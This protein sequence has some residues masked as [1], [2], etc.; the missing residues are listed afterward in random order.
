MPFDQDTRNRLNRFVSDARSLL[1]DEFTNLLQQRYGMDP[2]SGSVSPMDVL[3][4]LD[5]S[6]R[7]TARILRETL[8]YYHSENPDKKQTKKQ[9]LNRILREQAF[10]VLNRLCALRLA[11][12]R[13]LI[14]ETIAKGY[15][16]EGFLL[17]STLAGPALGETMDAYRTYLFSLFDELAVE[18]PPLFD[19]FSPEGRLFPRQTSLQDLLALIN[20]QDLIGLWSEDE[21]IGWIYQYFNSQEERRAMRAASSAPRNSRELAVRNQFFTPRYVVEFLTDNTLGRIWF[22]MTKGQTGL[23]D[24][25]NY[26]VRR[27]HTFFLDEGEEAPEPFDPLSTPNGDTD[28][29]GDMW[30]P[31]N[32]DLEE[33][34]HIFQYAVT[35]DGYHYAKE[36]L[37]IECGDLVNAKLKDY[38]ENGE[39]EGTFEELRCCLFFEQRRYHHFGRFPEGEEIETIQ[40]LYRAICERWDYEVEFVPFRQLKDPRE[41]KMLDPAC[42]SMHFGLYAFDLF[43][44]IYAEA[45]EVEE[46]N[47]ENALWRLADLDSLHNTYPNKES[48]ILDVPRLIIERNIHGIDIDQRAVQIAGL[49]LWLRAQ[50]TWSTL[51]M[52]KEVRPQIRK[53]NIVCAEPMP[54]NRNIL[55]EFLKTLNQ[56]HLKRMIAEMLPSYIVSS[57]RVTEKMV[58]ALR[59]LVREIWVAM[60]LAG[61]AGSLLKIEE[62]LENAVIEAREK[63][64]NNLP[65]LQA[66]DFEL[67]DPSLSNDMDFWNYSE[68]LVMLALKY[69]SIRSYNSNG[70]QR[71]VFTNDAL[72]GFGFLS[73]NRKSFDVV[74][75][76]PPFGLPSKASEKYLSQN[77]PKSKKDIYAIFVD[78]WGKK[79]DKGKLGVISNRT[80]MFL[81]TMQKW[82]EDSLLGITKISILADLGD[83]VLDNALVEA[84][85]YVITKEPV[86][87]CTIFRL[88]N[89]DNKSKIL[90]DLIGIV[91]KENNEIYVKK[92]NSFF[93][94][95]DSRIAYW[96]PDRVRRIFINLKNLDDQDCYVKFGLSTKDDY[97]FLRLIWEVNEDSV[98]FDRND[99]N[100]KNPWMFLAKGGD[101]SLFYGDI[102]ILANWANRGEELTSSITKKYS[103]IKGD[104]NWVLHREVPYGNP[105]ITYTRRTTSGF[106]PR[107]LP[108]GALI[109]DVGATIYSEE[110][111]DLP[112]ILSIVSSRAFGYLIEFNIAAGDTVHSGSAARTYEIGIISS[113]PIPNINS[114]NSE[115]GNLT[116]DIWLDKA[117]LDQT[118]ET[119]RFFV[120]P[121]RFIR[122]QMNIEDLTKYERDFFLDKFVKILSEYSKIDNHI[123][124]L[125]SFDIKAKNACEEEFG[126]NPIE[127]QES[128]LSKQMIKDLLSKDISK[129]IK[130]ATEEVGFK[131]YLSK[132]TFIAD[133]KLELICHLLKINPKSLAQVIKTCDPNIE[134]L[135]KT[136]VNLISYLLGCLFGRWDITYCKK[137]KKFPTPPNP[138]ELIRAIQPGNLIFDYESSTNPERFQNDYP[139]KVAW[140]GILVDDEFH[141][142]D[143]ESGIRK[144]L[145]IIWDNQSGAIEAEACQILQVDSLREYFRRYT[146]FFDDHYK[147]YSKSRRYAPIYWPLSTPSNSYT[148]WLYYHRIDDQI[149]FTCV[150]DFVDP[151]LKQVSADITRLRSKQSRSRSDEDNLEK[152]TDLEIELKEFREELLRI[153]AFWKP[154]LND[155]VE[156]TASPLWRLFQHRSWKKR[157]KRTWERLEEGEYD[158][159]HLAF[160]IWPDRVKE[161]CKTDK[162]IAIAHDLEHLYEG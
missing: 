83:G 36:H 37:G 41:I 78:R 100:R 92:I 161:K 150:N 105:G 91:L 30:L 49:S 72:Q 109:S 125:Y 138:F 9:V 21:T 149:L 61:E 93:D 18:L 43:E 40:D 140:K 28:L 127:Y 103:Y 55:E 96:A 88:L 124:K 44:Q 131:R 82:R 86:N 29:P 4:D 63:S 101:Y 136:C 67:S 128:I 98:V 7:E 90:N 76:N 118:S 104:A 108:K 24:V 122:S 119:S 139:L 153:A 84:A 145:D 58:Q 42:G 17:Y 106:S 114:V 147:R 2:T 45:W 50:K 39:W 159:A 157:L 3:N 89:Y 15:K 148:I 51:D 70:F 73:L 99:A 146:L 31:P 158:W 10:T 34:E 57:L 26:L 56:E 64:G 142:N 111:K 69:Y 121:S 48:L 33:I 141:S 129:I 152:L 25:C 126:K 68:Q 135:A 59:D 35:V 85:A 107:V 154:N 12:A 137:E 162:S 117:I 156:I 133:R 80:G 112:K 144:T 20:A 32:P 132:M 66:L 5:D 1:T 155:G 11:E 94:F 13:G 60:E 79:I 116:L 62:I 81:T 54:G 27:K 110:E 97:R 75:M 74:L 52:K 23:L 65:L 22:E 95:P 71:R 134:E 77:F 130:L 120:S 160:T 123:Y 6:Q 151:K 102:H 19:R 87:N 46:E 53:S 16:S 115:I 8:D 113:I 47:G 143:I 38:Q 14:L